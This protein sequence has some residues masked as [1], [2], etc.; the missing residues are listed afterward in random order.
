[1]ADPQLNLSDGSGTGVLSGIVNFLQA[2]GSVVRVI[3]A[4]ILGLVVSPFIALGDIIR[5]IGNFFSTPFLEG[6]NA[7]GQLINALFTAPGSL[8]ETGAQISEDTLAIFLGDSL[9]GV[10]ALPVAIGVVMLSLYFITLYLQEEET[11]DTLPGVPFDVPDILGIQFGVE[12]E[13]EEDE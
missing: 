8:I 1:M 10:L 7:I 13:G 3:E 12:E 9:A 5:A 4:S 11:G 2:G 6:G